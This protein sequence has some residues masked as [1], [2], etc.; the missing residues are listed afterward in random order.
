M[1]RAKRSMTPV[2]YQI[3]VSLKGSKPPIWRRIQ[4]TGETTLAQLH[5]ILQRV[6]GWESYHLYQFVVGG[7]EYGDPGMLEEMEGED[8]RRVTLATLVRGEKDTFLYEYDFGD[9]W[10]HELLIEKVLP[11][12]AGKRYPVC[13]TGKRACPP[14]DCGGIWGYAGFLDAI[15]DPQH[16]EHEEMLA[17]VGGEF[18][19]EAFD[20]DEVNREL[21]RLK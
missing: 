21:Q 14:E 4:V 7:I 12:E 15:Q 16:P 8:A 2:V 19:P 18:D 10:D 11:F 3:K 9:S 13:L 1:A 5:R 6:M 17:W 20:V